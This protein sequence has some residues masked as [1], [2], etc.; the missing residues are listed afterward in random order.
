MMT[1]ATDSSEEGVK[2]FGLRNRDIETAD[3]MWAFFKGFP[4]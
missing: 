2:R 1:F 3:E 4:R